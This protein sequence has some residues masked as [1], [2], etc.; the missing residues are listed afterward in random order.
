MQ[1]Q[2][3]YLKAFY[4]AAASLQQYDIAREQN[5]I[6]QESY[7]AK[8]SILIDYWGRE[9]YPMHQGREERQERVKALAPGLLPLNTIM[10]FTNDEAVI[11]RL[12]RKSQNEHRH[13]FVLSFGIVDI[14]S[15]S[16]RMDAEA[17]RF[18][19]HWCMASP[20]D[21]AEVNHLYEHYDIGLM[22]G[23]PAN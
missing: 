23:E 1:D 12:L 11:R 21:I 5:G 13:L 3:K 9:D 7:H 17:I 2:P 6:P 16:N 22:Q 14:N 4:A 8:R 19:E 18:H 10:A 20:E 15:I